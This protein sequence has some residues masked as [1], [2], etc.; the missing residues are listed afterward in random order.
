VLPLFGEAATAMR[1]T[2]GTARGGGV[3][4]VAG[5]TGGVGKRAVEVLL[6][7]GRAVRALVRDVEKAQRLLVRRRRTDRRGELPAR[8]AGMHAGAGGTDAADRQTPGC[9]PG[10]VECPG[11]TRLL[12]V[13]LVIRTEDRTARRDSGSRIR[14][15]DGRMGAVDGLQTDRQ[16]LAP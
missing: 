3:V 8:G 7:Q 1:A 5:A 13:A 14:C 16:G 12:A 11:Q 9:T 15:R 10:R 6:K 2:P 4:L